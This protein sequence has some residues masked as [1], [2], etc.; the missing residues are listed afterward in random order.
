ERVRGAVE[1]EIVEAHVAQEL[2]PTQELGEQRS[3]D[4]R[5]VA[6]ELELADAR[7]EG[8]DGAPDELVV[9][10]PVEANRARDRREARATAVR[11]DARDGRHR[12]RRAAPAHPLLDEP[13][14]ALAAFAAP[15]LGRER[16][17][18]RIELGHGERALGAR[19]PR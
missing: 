12:P 8:V 19:A 16:E 7:E 15:L 9:A 6:L 11:T 17:P 13:P 5:R 4:A 18:A 1:R 2:E 14:V 3:G 10:L